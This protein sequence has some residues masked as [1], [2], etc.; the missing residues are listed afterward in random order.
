MSLLLING[1]ISKLWLQTQ[2]NLN[3]SN[4]QISV[5]A[6]FGPKLV[7]KFEFLPIRSSEIQNSNCSAESYVLTKICA[8]L[9]FR[10]LCSKLVPLP[11]ESDHESANTKD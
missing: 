3:K 9:L 8:L 7:D 4:A 11:F 10:L 1:T 2:S 5:T 6:K